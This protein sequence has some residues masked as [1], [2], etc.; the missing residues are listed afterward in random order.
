MAAT[1]LRA[2]SSAARSPPPRSRRCSVRNQCWSPPADCGNT[3]NRPARSLVNNSLD[4]VVFAQKDWVETPLVVAALA[5]SEPTEKQP[6]DRAQK[7][8]PAGSVA[9]P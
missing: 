3:A 2:S 4:M 6:G 9:D 8:R 7:H 5:A 1:W